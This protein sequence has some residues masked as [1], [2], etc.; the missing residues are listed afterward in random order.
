MTG[1]SAE[2]HDSIY[3]YIRD[4]VARLNLNRPGLSVVDLGSFDVNGSTRDLFSQCDSY[5]GVD[6]R[7]GPGVDVVCDA[8]EYEPLRPV[9]VVV[10]T[11]TLEHAPNAFDVV[12]NAIRI[13]KPG[14]VFLGT[15]ATDPWPVHGCDGGELRAGEHYENISPERMDDWL[16]ALVEQPS[17]VIASGDGDL[18]WLAFKSE[19]D[20][21]WRRVTIDEQPSLTDY[22]IKVDI[23]AGTVRHRAGF[24]TIDANPATE[25]DIIA[26]LPPI[27]LPDES[28]EIVYASHF[29]EHL[30]QPD[31]MVLMAEVWRVLI[32]GGAAEFVVPYGLS[33]SALQ[34][35]THKS[36]FV[37]E[38]FHYYTEKYR[39]LKYDMETRFRMKG[40]KHDN[41]EVHVILVK[42]AE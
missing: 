11:S 23:G 34:D 4:T 5:V 19:S 33:E 37:P 31:V 18:C 24:V 29:L 17:W 20:R 36:F 41:T 30:A 1:G 6:V 12:V 16:N 32:P 21:H 7:L 22:P 2:L 9:D 25:P 27:P 38:S 15:C 3:A 39:Y 26:T 28:C 14:G 10:S 8:A 13:L 42:V 35:P 40:I